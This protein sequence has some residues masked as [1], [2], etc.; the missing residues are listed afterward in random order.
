MDLPFSYDSDETGFPL[1]GL[2]QGANDTSF[3]IGSGFTSMSFVIAHQSRC[4]QSIVSFISQESP[5]QDVR[6][7]LPLVAWTLRLT[8]IH[9]SVRWHGHD[10]HLRRLH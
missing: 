1:L 7:P 8:S 9:H 2:V 6:S 5:S 3:G 10:Q 4:W